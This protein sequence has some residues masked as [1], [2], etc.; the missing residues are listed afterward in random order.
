MRRS[1][2]Q[3][4]ELIQSMGWKSGT[5]E[6]EYREDGATFIYEVVPKRTFR[7]LQKSK[8]PGSDWLKIRD[9]YDYKQS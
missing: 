6:I 1:A 5:L 8:N 2:V 4:S 7:A 3:H 9:Q